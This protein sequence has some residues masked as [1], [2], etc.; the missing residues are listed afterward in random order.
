MALKREEGQDPIML[1]QVPLARLEEWIGWRN[2]LGGHLGGLRSPSSGWPEGE[3]SKQDG[4]GC[5]LEVETMETADGL[6]VGEE[7]DR[8]QDDSRFS[9]E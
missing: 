9:P 5:R 6:G 7:I 8:H 1:L 2:L 4:C 3:E